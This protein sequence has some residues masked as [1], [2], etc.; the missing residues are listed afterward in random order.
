MQNLSKDILIKSLSFNI[1]YPRDLDLFNNKIIKFSKDL[2]DDSDAFITNNF[3]ELGYAR[4]YSKKY[5]FYFSQ[6]LNE[7]DLI[8]AS[9]YGADGVIL[10]KIINKNLI[11]LARNSGFNLAFLAKNNTDLL[12]ATIYNFNIF[13]TN[14]DLLENI[15]NTK[16][17]GE[18][19]ELSKSTLA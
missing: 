6:N 7:D 11:N 15:P 9:I 1:F 16:L 14:K 10:D 12:K 8:K 4:R 2:N 18:L 19:Y 13:I 17:K 5:L 3:D